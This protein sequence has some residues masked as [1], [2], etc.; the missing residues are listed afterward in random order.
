M[1]RWFYRVGSMASVVYF[2]KEN[3]PA[4]GELSG[5]NVAL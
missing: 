2:T 1:L 3:S 4:R 5:V